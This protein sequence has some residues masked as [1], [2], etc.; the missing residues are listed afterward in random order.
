MAGTITQ[1]VSW[2]CYVPGLLAADEFVAAVKRAGFVAID[3]VPPEHWARVRDG[4]LQI[5]SAVGHASIELGLNRAEQHARIA[6]E[7]GA[8]IALTTQWGIPNLVCFS[9]SR[10]SATDAEAAHITAAGLARVS[11]AA[12]A[13]GVTLLLELLNSRVDH[14]GYQADRTDWGLQV[15]RLADAA[16]VRLLYDI[17]HMQIMEGDVIRTIER[18]IGSIAHFHTG[19]NPG[20]NDLDSSQELCYPAIL[21]AI[22]RTGFEGFVAHEF[23]PKGD[24]YQALQRTFAECAQALETELPT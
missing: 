5:S 21:A 16:C 24:P 14:P 11:G 12:T 1:S 23:I 9:G 6:Q 19:G 4:G 10:H 7:L 22:A 3:L 18:A 2:W 15:C 17:Y 8:N 13:A 20:R